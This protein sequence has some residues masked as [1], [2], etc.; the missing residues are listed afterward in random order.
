MSGLTTC[1]GLADTCEGCLDC[2]GEPQCPHLHVDRDV[3]EYCEDCGAAG[4]T[5]TG[6]PIR[7]IK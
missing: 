1:G 7:P 5:S 2:L 3:F 6:W 4:Y